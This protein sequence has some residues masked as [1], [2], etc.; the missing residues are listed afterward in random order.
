MLKKYSKAEIGFG[1]LAAFCVA[2]LGSYMFVVDSGTTAIFVLL[3]GAILVSCYFA[4]F[5]FPIYLKEDKA[6]AAIKAQK[7]QEFET[8]KRN[9]P[10]R[11]LKKLNKKISFVL[12]DFI[13]T[14]VALS[15]EVILRLGFWK[16]AN[17]RYNYD[18]YN[19]TVVENDNGE[20]DV[21]ITSWHY[22]DGMAVGHVSKT[23]VN[24]HS[25]K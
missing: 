10:V 13:G 7:E 19:L 11:E 20:E 3:G 12:N 14:D 25:F 18:G 4:I 21:K 23:Y 1:V 17:F 9:P 6:K 16:T 2:I 22:F 8:Y 5:M 15:Q 24:F